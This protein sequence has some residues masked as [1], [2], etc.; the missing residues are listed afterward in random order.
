M[1]LKKG[2]IADSNMNRLS[3]SCLFIAIENSQIRNYK[4]R[5]GTKH[6]TL[7][8]LKSSSNIVFVSLNMYRH[9][10]LTVLEKSKTLKKCLK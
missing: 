8:V 3:T 9:N 5:T 1:S 2:M 6:T 7:S 4:L 10:V